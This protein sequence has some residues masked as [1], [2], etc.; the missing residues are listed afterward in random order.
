MGLFTAFIIYFLAKEKIMLVLIFTEP[1]L[2]MATQV[3]PDSI[4]ELGIH[5]QATREMLFLCC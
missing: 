5:F 3:L 1:V 2:H 4:R